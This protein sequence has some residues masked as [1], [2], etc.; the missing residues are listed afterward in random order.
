MDINCPLCGE[1]WDAYGLRHDEEPG[2]FEK[3]TQGKGCPACGFGTKCTHCHGTG[4]EQESGLR[5][6]CHGDHFIIARIVQD[7]GQLWRF[8]CLENHRSRF[9]VGQPIDR[10]RYRLHTGYLPDVH[11]LTEEEQAAAVVIEAYKAVQCRDGWYAEAKLRCPFPH[12][13]PATPCRACQGSGK[14]IISPKAK[15]RADAFSALAEVLGDDTDG[16]Q[17]EL[18]D[19]SMLNP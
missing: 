11:K 3:V 9:P 15:A 17:A 1:P 16:L 19:L 8:P 14:L 7:S 6:R 10:A 2:T 4:R 13:A 18:E 12:P 5:C